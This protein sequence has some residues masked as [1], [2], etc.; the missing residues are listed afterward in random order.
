M[1]SEPWD[2]PISTGVGFAG[3]AASR[4]AK[5]EQPSFDHSGSGGWERMEVERGWRL[6]AGYEAIETLM[7]GFFRGLFGCLC[8][9]FGKIAT[10]LWY[11]LSLAS[12]MFF[13]E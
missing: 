3:R 13:H 12:I 7:S 2:P 9:T 5:F 1:K 6:G 8:S 11:F 10:V 4:T